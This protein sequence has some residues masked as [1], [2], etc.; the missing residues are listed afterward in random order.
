MSPR[1]F[2][3]LSGCTPQTRRDERHAILRRPWSLDHGRNGCPG[4]GRRCLQLAASL[5]SQ[6]KHVRCNERQLEPGD[7]GVYASKAPRKEFAVQ[8]KH[9]MAG[10]RMVELG[11][12]SIC[13][14]TPE[15]TFEKNDGCVYH[16]VQNDFLST[17]CSPFYGLS[18][19][20]RLC[21]N[22]CHNTQA[23]RPQ[24]LP[25]PHDQCEYTCII[26]YMYMS[27]FFHQYSPVTKA[28]TAK[29]ARQRRF[30]LCSLILQPCVNSIT[31]VAITLWCP[32]PSS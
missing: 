24:R 16:F 29:N 22:S 12:N 4:S 1:L 6:S 25:R 7:C 14:R 32:S 23:S 27:F 13:V 21:H 15:W 28:L 3:P 2:S 18:I 9:P 5:E 30:T 20:W 19:M 17:R 8:S 31:M 10:H 26:V 11:A